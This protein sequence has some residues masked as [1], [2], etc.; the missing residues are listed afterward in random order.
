MANR[1]GWEAF[2]AEDQHVAMKIS[3][4]VLDASLGIDTILA[5][6][7]ILGIDTILGV[8]SGYP[9]REVL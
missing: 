7:A 6:D 8:D 5:V 9:R 2:Q 3:G 4:T 1:S